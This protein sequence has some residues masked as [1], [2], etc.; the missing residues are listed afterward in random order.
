MKI[1]F[2]GNFGVDYSSESHYYKTL[3]SLGHEVVRIQEGQPLTVPEATIMSC[4]SIF[5]VH[6]HS[7]VTDGLNDVLKRFKGLIWGYHLDLWLGIDREKDLMT[8]DYWRILDVFYTVDPDMAEYL[9]TT[10]GMPRGVYMPA[11]VYD[12]E[13]YLA[14]PDRKYQ[15]DI[16]FVGSR[17]YHK[18]WPYRVKLIEWL[19]STYG[20]NFA[21]YG[22]GGLGT[23]RGHELNTLYAS[24]KIVV[25]DSLCPGYNKA[26]YWSDRIYETTGRGGFLIH[27]YIKGLENDFVLNY[28][29]RGVNRNKKTEVVVYDYDDFHYLAYLIDY[30]LANQE[31]REAIRIRGHERTKLDHTYAK[32]LS[33]ILE[34]IK[35]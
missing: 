7:W 12:A 19:E 31:A 18:E 1:A 27:P 3:L 20:S 5:W 10:E 30:Y 14:Q 16:V 32:R 28:D 25:G 22:G 29:Q 11:G 23:I 8:D 2:I 17:G 26:G 13:C 34:S 35:K 15:H 24:T 21:Q 9:N 4:D 33:K 6:T